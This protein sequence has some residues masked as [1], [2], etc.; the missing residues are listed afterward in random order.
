MTK[1]PNDH[2][3]SPG[4]AQ[5]EHAEP[6]A[7]GTS[8]GALVD[9]LRR[10]FEFLETASEMLASSLDF[11]TTL[12][13]VARLA[14]PHIADWCA[15]DICG[16]PYCDDRSSVQR[17]TVAHV[18]PEK[19]D[20][21]YEL[22]KK[23]PPDPDAP[24]GLPNVLRTGKS[25][26][27]GEIPQE[28]LTGAAV[29]EEHR[30]LIVELGLV[31]YM[32]V[33]LIVHE[34]V[35]GGI[36]F[37]SAESGRHYDEEDVALAEDLARRAAV[38]IDNA[39]LVKRV[40]L[41]ES[42]LRDQ[43]DFMNSIMSSLGDG[44]C[45]LDA[46]GRVTY[47]NPAAERM[48]GR[49]SGEII[50][51]G[52]HDLVHTRPD[53]GEHIRGGECA[54][55]KSLRSHAVNRNDDAL[56]LTGE[57]SLL[58]V[59]YTASPVLKEG[60][61]SGTIIA[62][63]DISERKRQEEELRAQRE[64]FQVTLASIGDAVIAADVHGMVTFLNPV[65][66][67]LT[68]WRLE[69]SSGIPLTEV[70]RIVNET[71]GEPVDNPVAEVLRSG[72]IVGLANHTILIRKDG[73]EIP[74]DDSAAP[75]R[76]GEEIAGVILVF[77][78]DVTEQ[79]RAE[80]ALRRS[81]QKTLRLLESIGDSF[82]ALDAE[83]RFSY[84]NQKAA[85]LFSRLGL[86]V[87]DIIDRNIWA[88]IPDMIW[89]EAYERF[90]QASRDQQP[91]QFIFQYPELGGWFNV[92]VY[93]S[94]E[95]LSIFLQDINDRMLRD[96]ERNR[97]LGEAEDSERRFRDLVNTLAGIFWEADPTT[98]RFLFVSRRAE[99]ILGYSIDDW[100]SRPNFWASIIHPADREK[101]VQA[102]KAAASAAMDHDLRYRAI[103]A[104]G[105][106][107]WLR[108]IVY[109]ARNENGRAERL[110]GVMVDVTDDK[111][112]D[113]HDSRVD[114]GPDAGPDTTGGE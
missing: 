99:A 47:L 92:Y 102:R 3:I 104:D 53:T 7:S 63:H 23:Y 109:V 50:G 32:V 16:G 58:P 110:R 86:E 96:E 62:F 105:R 49:S 22:E 72:Q 30:R 69:E 85:E 65:A 111:V 38:A 64:W 79:R 40:H 56:F 77:R 103:A 20:L 91:V 12:A 108:D 74:I 88:V 107:V 52:F 51:K 36:S 46:E 55:M 112:I 101:T 98:E 29:D 57:G 42:A 2:N 97:L 78:D 25:E 27:M 113:L 48:L 13:N 84:V 45:A 28:L 35:L 81:T 11:K 1:K 21:A 33:P 9:D 15:V 94:Y 76:D 14:V 37:V 4:D 61:F 34:R 89:T 19:V 26:Y 17:L 5:K 82:I 6:A 60:A 59:E 80:D 106:T 54:L 44:V 66:E 71:T 100:L 18:D 114:E 39:N 70:F 87:T 75:I 90:H 93:P 83:W 67:E 10:R 68:G 43:L 24:I 31:S 73:T 41:A 95:G 8:G